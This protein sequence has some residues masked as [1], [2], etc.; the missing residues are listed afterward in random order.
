MTIESG[1]IIAFFALVASIYA[2]YQ[3]HKTNQ[4]Q[5]G[6]FELEKELNLFLIKK[7][8]DEAES[9]S[10]AD[11]KGRYFKIGGSEYRLKLWNDGFGKAKDITLSF[12][13]DEEIP[14]IQSDIDRKFPLT[15]ESKQSV[16]LLA[17]VYLGMPSKH[18]LFVKWNDESNS[19]QLK[20]IVLTI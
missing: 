9:K 14:L 8:Q 18:S 13:D 7:E 11:I 15:L 19:E 1:D 3:N 5:A 12:K 6:L 17:S 20:E 2:I 4:R 16:E 10:R